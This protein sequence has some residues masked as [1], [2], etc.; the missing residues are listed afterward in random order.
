MLHL[1][2]TKVLHTKFV[3]TFNLLKTHEKKRKLMLTLP[4]TSVGFNVLKTSHHI[5]VGLLQKKTKPHN[6]GVARFNQAI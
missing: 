6:M 3:L 5:S 2:I 1:Q 4:I